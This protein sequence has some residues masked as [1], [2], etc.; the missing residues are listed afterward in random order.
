MKSRMILDWTRVHDVQPIEGALSAGLAAFAEAAAQLSGPDSG[1]DESSR[2]L[3]A[4]VLEWLAAL[5]SHS[6]ALVMV[7]SQTSSQPVRSLF[8]AGIPIVRGSQRLPIHWAGHNLSNAALVELLDTLEGATPSLVLV[9][10]GKDVSA[11]VAATFRVLRAA[12]AERYGSVEARH[13]IAVLVQG[14]ESPA[15]EMA[16]RFGYRILCCDGLTSSSVASDLMRFAVRA[17]G[18]SENELIAGAAQARRDG[19][20]INNGSL[21][22]NPVL[23]YASVRNSLLRVGFTAETLCLWSPKLMEMGRWWQGQ[24]VMHDGGTKQFFPAVAQFP[25]DLANCETGGKRGV[26]SCWMTHLAVQDESSITLGTL[27]RKVRIP[28]LEGADSWTCLEGQDV[29][30]LIS[31]ALR[32]TVLAFGDAKI[33]CLVWE[34]PE[35]S[36]YWVAYWMETVRLGLAV[37]AIE[38]GQQQRSSLDN[39]AISHWS[40]L[41]GRVIEGRTS[42]AEL[43]TRLERGQRLRS[44]G[45]TTR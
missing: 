12:F 13:R 33:P 44:L 14:P 36:P 30:S 38:R 6:D 23:T 24:L 43:R 19:L 16:E 29:S 31:E 21:E 10:D 11:E 5:P 42:G 1:D 37:A 39:A 27:R 8:A 45:M 35:L 28:P 3:N 25:A 26:G 40:A 7:A 9:D 15:V 2:D 4:A 34:L 17:H 41:A 32:A 20:S 18:L 22:T